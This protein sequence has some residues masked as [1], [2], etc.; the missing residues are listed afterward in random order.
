MLSRMSLTS[1]FLITGNVAPNNTFVCSLQCASGKN[2][3]PNGMVR[4]NVC[5]W[6]LV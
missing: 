1:G 5:Y 4:R 3:A 6:T 2:A